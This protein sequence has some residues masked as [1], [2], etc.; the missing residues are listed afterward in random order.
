MSGIL[1]LIHSSKKRTKLQNKSSITRGHYDA[2]SGIW[3]PN[4][5]YDVL[6]AES[7]E[8]NTSET[9]DDDEEMVIP[10][11]LSNEVKDDTSENDDD[12]EEM[13]IPDLL[14]DEVKDDTSENED[15]KEKML[16]PATHQM[17]KGMQ[18]MK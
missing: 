6:T 7:G 1:L 18:P 4:N 5:R 15:N 11:L 12:K 16:I 14:S 9:D 8:E 17:R 13:V 10:D 2:D 3:R